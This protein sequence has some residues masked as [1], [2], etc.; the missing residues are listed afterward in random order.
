M[1]KSNR[2]F[3]T[4]DTE[5]QNK[6]GGAELFIDSPDAALVAPGTPAP[7]RFE[8]KQP[9]L[10]KGWHFNLYNN[11]WGTNFPMWYEEDARFRFTIRMPP[12][13]VSAGLT[14]L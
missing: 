11:L 13:E 4:I 5:L 9:D 7:L 2:S 6:K 10:S 1:P 12:S 8:N 14:G 3:H